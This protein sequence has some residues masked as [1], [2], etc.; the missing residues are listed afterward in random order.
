MKKCILSEKI[1]KAMEKICRVKAASRDSIKHLF[2][3]GTVAR[4]STNTFLF[5]Q[6]PIEWIEVPLHRLKIGIWGYL[7][8]SVI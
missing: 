8:G 1:E 2:L 3:P 4:C 5:E 7:G 6:K